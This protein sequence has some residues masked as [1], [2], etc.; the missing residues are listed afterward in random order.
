MIELV[1]ITL[2]LIIVAGHVKLYID[3]GYQVPPELKK[4]YEDVPFGYAEFWDNGKFIKYID[5]RQ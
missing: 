4:Y 1:Q 5:L 2:I 3:T